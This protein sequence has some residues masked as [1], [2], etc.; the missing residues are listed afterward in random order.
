MM[1][2]ALPSLDIPV[3]KGTSG[4]IA[5]EGS[6]ERRR[7]YPCIHCGDCVEACPMMLNPSQLGLLARHGEFETAR[8][9]HLFDCFECG[10]CAYV[11]PSHLPLVQEIRIAKASLRKQAAHA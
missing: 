1:G 4:I 10:A 2:V 9:H 8:Q 6:R 7:V 11:C 3:T 5:L